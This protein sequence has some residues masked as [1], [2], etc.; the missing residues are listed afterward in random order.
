MSVRGNIRALQLF[1]SHPL[2][3]CQFVGAKD[4]L[5]YAVAGDESVHDRGDIRESDAPVKE[6]VGLDQ[7]SHAG[8]ALVETTRRANARLELGQAAHSHF[9]FQ[10]F[11][12]FLGSPGCAA[13]FRVV[14]GPAI[15]AN[16]EVALAHGMRI[17]N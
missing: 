3:R 16:E 12:D 9:C 5:F 1:C 15:D 4:K 13:A 14:V 2:G 10:C 7:N 8:G 6:V 11:V 17:T